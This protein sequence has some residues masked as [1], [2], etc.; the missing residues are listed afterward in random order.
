[1]KGVSFFLLYLFISITLE[2][3][4]TWLMLEIPAPWGSSAQEDCGSRPA[5]AKS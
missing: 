1:M 3:K 4:K 5:Q 2:K